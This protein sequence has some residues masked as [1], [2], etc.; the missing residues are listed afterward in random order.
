M[1]Q[2]FIAGTPGTVLTVPGVPNESVRTVPGDSQR[3]AG[4]FLRQLLKS[5]K[6][7]TENTW[8]IIH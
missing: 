6:T 1:R 8:K 2:I 3:R 5:K 7:R 4:T